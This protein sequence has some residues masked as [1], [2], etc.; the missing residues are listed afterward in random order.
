MIHMTEDQ[1]HALVTQL[2]TFARTVTMEDIP[3]PV[4]HECKRSLIDSLG[5]ITGG[6]SHPLVTRATATLSP[7]FGP[8]QASLLGQGKQADVLHAA[9]LNGT[10]GAAYS[11][12][13]NYSAAHLHAGGSHAGALIALAEWKAASGQELLLAYAT[14]MEIACRLTKAIAHAPAEMDVGW[15]TGGIV[16]GLSIALA[17]GRLLGLSQEQMVWALG[18][19]ASQAAGMRI[20]HGSMTASML[21]GQASQTG[22][23][24]AILAREGFTSP[25]HSLYGRFGYTELFAHKTNLPALIAGLGTVWEVARTN[26]KPYP[27][28]IAI[29][30]QI[31]AMLAL[32]RAHGFEGA[33]ISGI[34]VQSSELAKDFCD[35]PAPANSLEAKFSS[36]HW[37]AAAALHGRV[38][39]DLG[40]DEVVHDLEI[41]RLRAATKLIEKGELGWNA[42]TL[43][44]TL[45][46]GQTVEAKVDHC[47]GSPEAPMTDDDIVEKCRSQAAQSIGAERADKLPDLCWSLETVANAADL[48]RAAC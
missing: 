10:A 16:N 9:L 46:S 18:I 26:Y 39:L 36:Q 44:V 43:C 33:D 22:L 13:D 11:F 37:I 17:A 14:G 28:D 5:C 1:N 24:A 35:R 21:Y 4:M 40:R 42:T 38:G 12:F 31:Q 29:H 27:T 7:F 34:T 3:A 47:I 20:A 15:S 45:G 25:A 23:R 30:A 48:A 19:A 32:K 2:V 8:A 6:G 41:R